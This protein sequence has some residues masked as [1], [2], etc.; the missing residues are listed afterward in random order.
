MSSPNSGFPTGVHATSP[1]A[2]LYLAYARLLDFPTF[3]LMAAAGTEELEAELR[4][5][6]RAAGRVP[7]PMLELRGEDLEQEYIATFEVGAPES[8]VPLYESAYDR[9][10]GG[11]RRSI[12]EE[13]VRFYEFFDMDLGERPVEQ[14]DHVTVELEFMAVLAQMESQTADRPGLLQPFQR[15]QRDFLARHLLPFAAAIRRRPIREGFYGAILAGLAAFMEAEY[16]RLQA[17]CGPIQERGR[18]TSVAVEL[19]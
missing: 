5:L 11:D 10:E 4:T 2:V 7:S 6:H 14:P 16:E 8:P 1:S 19:R 15:A 3:E 12:L 18:R 9:P 13:L 17:A